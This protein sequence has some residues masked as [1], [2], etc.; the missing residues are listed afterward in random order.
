MTRWQGI[1]G[2]KGLLAQA[3]ATAREDLGCPIDTAICL[4]VRTSPYGIFFISFQTL[5]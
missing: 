5:I 1:I 4:Y 3:L 2:G